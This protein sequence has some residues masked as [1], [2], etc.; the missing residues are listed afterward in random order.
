MDNFANTN[1]NL[2]V[3]GVLIHDGSVLLAR[4]TYGSGQNMLVF[5]GGY[6]LKGESPQQAIIREFKEET[7]VTVHPGDILG[8]R[9]G[10]DNWYA[11]FRVDYVS[12]KPKSDHNE[13]SE[14]LWV[15]AMEALEREDVPELT[16]S[17]IRAAFCGVGGLQ[18]DD[19]HG[20]GSLYSSIGDYVPF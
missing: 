3:A 20:K 7:S 18:Q 6:L 1:W 14:V 12:G 19:Y 11:V 5:P 4:H 2:S 16:K 15:E 13:N 9:F 10:E 17:M 8:I